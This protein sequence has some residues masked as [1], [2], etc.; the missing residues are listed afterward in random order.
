MRARAATGAM[1]SEP[2]GRGGQQ[3]PQ[4]HK[5]QRRA[6]KRRGGPSGW[7]L[8][9][10]PA[11][12]TSNQALGKVKR[13]LGSRRAGHAGNLDP[14]A[15]GMLPI[16]L[17]E[18][19]K[20]STG[21]LDADKEYDTWI[22]LGVVT[23]T[24][25]ADGQVLRTADSDAV[26]Q[27]QVEQALPR[28][29]GEIQQI[30]PMYSALKHEGTRLYKL[31]RQGEVVDRPPRTVRIHSLR[32]LAFE[33]PRLRLHLRCTK[34]TY[35]RT[36]AEDL[37]EVL[38][39]GGHME[40]LRRTSVGPLDEERMVSLQELEAMDPAGRLRQVLP[41][42]VHMQEVPAVELSPSLA[43]LA[44]RGMKVP[45][46]MA[47]PPGR[48]RLC[49]PPW[50]FIGLGEACPDGVIKPRR[51]VVTESLEQNAGGSGF[52]HTP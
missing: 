27:S 2:G 39:C 15:T 22:R 13:L 20:F 23:D 5:S 34:G 36:L 6:L 52:G 49:A 18:A 42:D 3:R 51:M 4:G 11:G 21:L 1:V 26:T 16:C 31:A 32:L 40:Q 38:G 43:E 28:F 35:V 17:G 44:L 19:T 45:L 7:L 29:R 37:G 47:V 10:K 48:V 9:D 12:I 24:A 25:D 8:L 30:P 50:G 33:P 46:R 41:C 14:I